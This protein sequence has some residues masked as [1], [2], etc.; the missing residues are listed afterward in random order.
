[1]GP[2]KLVVL[3][4][5]Y[6]TISEP[7]TQQL[8]AGEVAM[9]ILGYQASY[10]Y[11]VLPVDTTEFVGRHAMVCEESDK[12]FRVLSATKSV[13][14]SLCRAFN[15]PFPMLSLAKANG[16]EHVSYVEDKIAQA[17]KEGVD[18]LYQFS[19]SADPQI[20][21]K[22][23]ELATKLKEI[24]LAQLIW[25]AID[26]A[27]A[28][29]MLAGVPRVKTDQFFEDMGYHLAIHQ[30][31]TLSPFNVPTSLGEKAV[32]MD[33]KE[34]TL[35]ARSLMKRYQALWDQRIVIAGKEKAHRKAA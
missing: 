16:P 32:F 2:L 35:Q 8:L 4:C 34:I 29:I 11:G 31:Q 33:F 12:G 21:A 6:D 19:W 9:K 13:T 22:D 7:R 30:G 15:I 25:E 28:K 1:M 5:A 26:A 23:R 18:L 17:D 27:P 20:R 3:D 10:P 24:I 14:L